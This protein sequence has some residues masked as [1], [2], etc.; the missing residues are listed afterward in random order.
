MTYQVVLERPEGH[1]PRLHKLVAR[2]AV[3][4]AMVVKR[5]PPHRIHTLLEYIRQGARPATYTEALTARNAA[6]SVSLH[7]ASREGCLVRSIAAALTCRAFGSW[8]TWCVG[9][10]TRSPFGAHAWIE[11]ENRLVSEP[12]PYEYLSRLIAVP[13]VDSRG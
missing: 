7:C 5:L 9:V 8:P 12:V 3:A 13:A 1:V 4:G 2:F 10:R 6:I 11:A